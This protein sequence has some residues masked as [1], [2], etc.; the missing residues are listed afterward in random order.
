[1]PIKTTKSLSILQSFKSSF[2]SLSSSPTSSS[3]SPSSSPSL[4][5]SPK[6]PST[7]RKSPKSPLHLHSPLS[8]TMMEETIS[9]AD[10][11]ISK[12]A[13]D[14]GPFFSDRR[15]AGEFLQII[16]NLQQSM[17]FLISVPHPNSH[18][19]LVRA[20]TLMQAA[21]KRLE[22]EFHHILAANRNYPDAESMSDH[23]SLRSGALDNEGCDTGSEEDSIQE[24]QGAPMLDLRS[25]AEC[26]IS[27]GYGK[28]CVRIYRTVR[29]S[30]LDEGLY[31]LGFERMNPHQIH[32]LDWEMAEPRIRKW[33]NSSKAA[34]KT[35]FSGERALCD[36]VFAASESVR[37]T[38]FAEI[39]KEAAVVL[40]VFPESIAGRCKKSPERILPIL[41]LCDALSELMP[42]VE[43][44]FSYES[45]SAV[46]SQAAAALSKASDVA[47]YMIRD[48]ETA[49]QKDASRTPAAGGGIH[50][51]TR[52]AMDYICSLAEY[53]RILT[54]IYINHPL[55]VQSPFLGMLL[56]S[57]P[58][59]DT[60]SSIVA[61]RFAWLVLVLL[62]KLDGKAEL[63]KDVG[64]SYLFL[65]N[66]H[67]YIIAKTRTSRLQY[68]LGYDWIST[69]EAKAQ[70]YASGY[71]KTTWGK[72]F[73]TLPE[74]PAAEMDREA[75]AEV[76]RRFSQAFAAVLRSQAEWVVPDGKMREGIKSSVKKKMAAAYREFWWRYHRAAL[77]GNAN[78]G[79]I[80]TPVHLEKCL[81]E[82]FLAS[83]VSD[84][85]L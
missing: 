75:A 33:L 25:I 30:V 79:E 70:Q 76:G 55:P 24:V 27:S 74:D 23:S 11:V 42:D 49:M 67:E 45:T 69:H 19:D 22:R 12:H 41:D 83:A 9:V 59:A 48:F 6:C 62:C 16:K 38:C 28:E 84:S 65:A 10:A 17:L 80:T 3:S 50:P 44:I 60:P 18:H 34:V 43:S 39:A 58:A 36:H 21:M 54:E 64:L 63:Y 20:Q 71:E 1:M 35:L 5:S 26:M 85:S 14:H 7:P 13:A 29:K 77:L 4:S 31:T 68:I 15:Q 47:R 52:D 66:N 8:E 72:V 37:E 57:S 78:D 2:S 73:A 46:R 61:V 53:H 56:D 32:K 51:L 81:S 40:F 82:L